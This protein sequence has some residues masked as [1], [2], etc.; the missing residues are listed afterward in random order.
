MSVGMV[1]RLYVCVHNSVCVWLGRQPD[2]ANIHCKYLSTN[3]LEAP[4]AT[5]LTF[6]SSQKEERKICERVLLVYSLFLAFSLCSIPPL[7]TVFTTCSVKFALHL[8]ILDFLDKQCLTMSF[9]ILA[10]LQQTGCEMKKWQW[11][12]DFHLLVYTNQCF[13]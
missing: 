4:L 2:L 11:G 3:L 6:S 8:I 13:Y 10:L 1:E 9:I 7:S 12:S 5:L